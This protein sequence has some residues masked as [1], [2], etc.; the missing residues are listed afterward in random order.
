MPWAIYLELG[1]IE[2]AK[3]AAR[4]VRNFVDTELIEPLL[5]S[6]EGKRSKAT[7]TFFD[8][9]IPFLTE[10]EAEKARMGR[11]KALYCL[12]DILGGHC[13]VG[14]MILRV[15]KD[16]AE[17]PAIQDVIQKELSEVRESSFFTFCENNNGRFSSLVRTIYQI[18][19]RDLRRVRR[20][21]VVGTVI[22]C[23]ARTCLLPCNAA[24][25]ISGRVPKPVISSPLLFP[26]THVNPF[27]TTL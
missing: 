15:L 23:Q 2:R 25:L 6:A 5:V 8:A 24:E 13:A 14:C 27:F 17:N 18:W 10:T 7:A 9:L 11:D 22:Y 20:K 19:Q 1:H 4:T 12:E 16:L 26:M 21:A 3:A